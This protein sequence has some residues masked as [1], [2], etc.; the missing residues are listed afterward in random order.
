MLRYHGKYRASQGTNKTFNISKEMRS[1]T[2]DVEFDKPYTFEIQVET[3]AGRSDVS[4][5]SWF[6]HSGMLLIYKCE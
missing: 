4:N 1:I 3:E 5:K 2:V 6:S